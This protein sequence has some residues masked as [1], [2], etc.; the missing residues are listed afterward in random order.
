MLE[1]LAYKRRAALEKELETDYQG[2][3]CKLPNE[4]VVRI[5]NTG[6]EWQGKLSYT[7][8]IHGGSKRI[9]FDYTDFKAH[10]IIYR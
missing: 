1:E 6:V 7:V 4:Q 10:T 5:E 3:L 8:I 9:I 2:K